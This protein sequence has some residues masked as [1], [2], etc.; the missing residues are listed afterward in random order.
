MATR[1]SCAVVAAAGAAAGEVETAGSASSARA[2]RCWI[3][4]VAGV[5]MEWAH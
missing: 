4:A 5:D 3:R 2:S 1:C